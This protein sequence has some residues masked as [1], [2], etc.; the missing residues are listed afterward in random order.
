MDKTAKF[1]GSVSEIEST[2]NK[3]NVIDKNSDDKQYPSAA[4]VFRAINGMKFLE[5]VMQKF[6]IV[7]ET[8]DGGRIITVTND[9][10]E[11][12]DFVFCTSEY[13][14]AEFE[15]GQLRLHGKGGGLVLIS[16]NHEIDC[17][18]GRLVNVDSPSDDYDAANKL[19]VDTA[20]G[21]IETALDGIIAIQESLIGGANAIEIESGGTV[22][23]DYPLPEGQVSI[24]FDATEG[25][26][27]GI[28]V[29]NGTT[30]TLVGIVDFDKNGT[31][32]EGTVE[33]PSGGYYP[34]YLSMLPL[35]DSAVIT[36]LVISREGGES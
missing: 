15:A 21:D 6:G 26:I 17:S 19:Y 33:V 1:D 5:N 36:N 32:Y 31:H 30:E 35:G 28:E 4:A 12:V 3:V 24:S 10:G 16:E 18:D 9:E 8:A 34:Y 27:N 14:G 22:L 2:K 25:G 13:M 7:T 29:I 20:I 11:P 23:S